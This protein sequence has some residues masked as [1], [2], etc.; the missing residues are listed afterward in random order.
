MAASSV[1]GIAAEGLLLN[2]LILP[3]AERIIRSA[4]ANMAHTIEN[5]T[6]VLQEFR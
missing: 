2:G 5:S 4:P 6:A 1:T 3:G